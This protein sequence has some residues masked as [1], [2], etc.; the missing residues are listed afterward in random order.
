[1]DFCWVCFLLG[2]VSV[3]LFCCCE[4][5]V[6]IHVAHI[7]R[8][9]FARAKAAIHVGGGGGGGGGGLSLIFRLII[10][11]SVFVVVVVFSAQGCCSVEQVHVTAYCK[12]YTR[13]AK[14]GHCVMNM[15]RGICTEHLV[16]SYSPRWAVFDG[17]LPVASPQRSQLPVL[18]QVNT[19]HITAPTTPITKGF[20]LL[21][22]FVPF[23]HL[24]C[25]F[26]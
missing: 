2:A 7:L 11:L 20:S 25:P 4:K 23:F 12:M 3:E 19:S 16:Y 6:L 15:F 17:V 8:R 13:C 24:L 14:Q 9:M 10:L 5:R 21:T 1:M 26:Q 18:C 22:N